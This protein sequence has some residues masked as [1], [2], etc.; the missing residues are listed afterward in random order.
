[1]KMFKNIICVVALMW[2]TAS[3][4]AQSCNGFG[5]GFS[6]RSFFFPTCVSRTVY[7]SRSYCQPVMDIARPR[8]VC[9]QP[10]RRPV[11]YQP[12]RRPVYYQPVRRPTCYQTGGNYRTSSRYY[13]NNFSRR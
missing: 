1:M 2:M 5:G 12:V 8:Q 3:V 9:Y 10:V 11:C 13:G 7:T 6:I 4:H